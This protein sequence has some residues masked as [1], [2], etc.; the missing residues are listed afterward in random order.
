[1]TKTQLTSNCHYKII[2]QK[3]TFIVLTG[4]FFLLV[5]V[6]AIQTTRRPSYTIKTNG[7]L[8]I[9][10]KLSSSI[11]VFD[12]FEGKE[13]VT[14]P[15]E[16]EPHEATTLQ[17]LNKV[18]VTNYGTQKVIGKS[19]SIINLESNTIEK[20]IILQES[21]KPHGIVAFPKTN[22]VGI[23]TNIG[24]DLVIVNVA[25]GIVEKKI[26]THQLGSH[27]LVLHP[28]KPFAYVSNI[29]SGSVSVIDLLKGQ[30]CA[31]IS[32]GKG[33]E[34]I[35]ITPDGN[36]I[37]AIN[38][39]E[40]TISIINTEINKI[41]NTISTRKESLRLN[42]SVD[43]KFCLVTNSAD[44]TITIHN[45]YTKRSI[46]T[47]QVPEKK[48]FIDRLLYHTPRPGGILVHP[49]GRYVF[50]ANSNA[51]KIEVFDMRTFT[52]VSTI[53]TGLVPDGITFVE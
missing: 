20:T 35:A 40:N 8:Y 2:N 15:V 23:V 30:V 38:K 1:M 43:G 31:I 53:G 3:I 11:T 37:W 36:E 26:A 44:G 16:I 51:N 4:V 46:K 50:I 10:N 33:T 42:F 21:L 34:G 18:V 49:N 22:K 13:M 14:F 41:I 45:R 39:N 32:C 29:S 47:I 17:S 27:L 19:I 7:K 24:N 12:L 48:G 52:L 25:T 5:I 6:I 28:Q 9:V